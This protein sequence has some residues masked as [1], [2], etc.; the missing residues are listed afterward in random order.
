MGPR[1]QKAPA[2]PQTWRDLVGLQ[3][4]ER[5]VRDICLDVIFAVFGDELE[6]KA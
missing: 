3:A 2:H 6:G 5:L 1:A 4:V